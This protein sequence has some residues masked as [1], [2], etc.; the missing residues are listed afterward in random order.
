MLQRLCET[1]HKVQPKEDPTK[2]VE[3][4]R[5]VSGQRKMVKPP[6]TN[7]QTAKSAGSGRPPFGQRIVKRQTRLLFECETDKTPPQERSRPQT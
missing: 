1:F 3:S 4:D 2:T 7:A 6:L 5:M